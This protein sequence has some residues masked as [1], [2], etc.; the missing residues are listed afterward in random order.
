MRLSIGH[1][2]G[3]AAG[4]ESVNRHLLLLV[5]V[6]A[7]AGDPSKRPENKNEHDD[8]NESR[9]AESVTFAASFDGGGMISEDEEVRLR[10]GD[11]QHSPTSGSTI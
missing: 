9:G 4:R 5:A 3:G 6:G 8:T 7:N 11:W 2:W 10:A 1:G